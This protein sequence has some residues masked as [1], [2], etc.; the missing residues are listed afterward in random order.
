MWVIYSKDGDK[1][2]WKSTDRQTL[3]R[4]MAELNKALGKKFYLKENKEN[5]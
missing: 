4:M 2:I 3:T 1:P 5:K